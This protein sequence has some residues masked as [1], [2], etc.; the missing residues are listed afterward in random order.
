MY[1]NQ[2]EAKQIRSA[3]MATARYL[4]RAIGRPTPFGLFA[5]VAPVTLGSTARVRWGTVHRAVVRADTQWLADVISR[6]EACRDLLERLDVVLTNLAIQRGGWLEAPHG[7]NRVR[8]RCTKAVRVVQDAAA[9][10]VRF[11]VLAD[12][13]FGGVAH[14]APSCRSIQVSE[15]R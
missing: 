11:S 5:G 12:K 6:L 14:Q 9:S 7:P 10:P 2:S 1:S 13:T 15:P 8:I 4:L 3:T